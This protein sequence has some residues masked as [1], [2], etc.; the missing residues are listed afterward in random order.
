MSYNFEDHLLSDDPL[1]ELD[2]ELFGRS[3][4]VERVIDVLGQ[5]RKQSTSSTIGLVG[6]W[7]SGKSSVLT[8]VLSRIRLNDAETSKALNREKWLVAEFNPWLF[9]DPHALHAGFFTTLRDA[10]PS[11]QKWKDVR[12]KVIQLGRYVA[13]AAG[14]VTAFFGGDGEPAASNLID[15]FELNAVKQHDAISKKLKDLQQPVLIVVDDL[16]RLTATELLEV[17]KLVRLVGRL[18]Y[19]YYVLS[20]DEHTLV[21]LL[22]KTDLVSAND[23]RRAL[24]Y[25]EKIVQVRLDM[26]LLRPF[27][28]DRVVDRALLFLARKH[29]VDLD[30]ETTQVLS[31]RFDDVMSNRLRT[32]R[33][34][35]RLFGQLDAFLSAVGNEVHFGDYVVVTWLRTMEPGVYDLIQRRRSQLL[36]IE[37]DPMRSLDAPKNDAG[38]RRSSWIRDLKAAHVASGDVEDVLW[39]LGTLFPVVGDAYRFGSPSMNGEA[40]PAEPGRI[41]HVDYFDRFFA[42]GV[43]SDDIPDTLARDALA[44]IVAGRADDSPRVAQ[45]L[46]A[47]STDPRLAL[48]KIAQSYLQTKTPSPAL[49]CWVAERW[50]HAS[51]RFVRGRLENLCATLSIHLSGDDTAIAAATLMST[52]EGL[53]FVSHLRGAL[54]KAAHTRGP[55]REAFEMAAGSWGDTLDPFLATRFAELSKRYDSPTKLSAPLTAVFHRWRNNNTPAAASFLETA[56]PE[57]WGWVDALMW[58]A[59]VTTPDEGKTYFLNPERNQ[60][61]YSDIFDLD[62]AVIDCGDEIMELD[63]VDDFREKEATPE[64]RRAYVLTVLRQRAEYN[65]MMEDAENFVNNI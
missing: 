21:D 64:A 51:D 62:T 13:P 17:F 50:H 52:D 57:R 8:S 48:R 27:E 20:Y 12:G 63:H 36:S 16:D 5:V 54:V 53:L 31:R 28:V 39:L 22:A 24:E 9:S 2:D 49:I 45:L 33:S 10:F 38:A 14:L 43:P 19:V 23:D 40:P 4:L 46:A 18:P 32:P 1:A 11:T 35:K 56:V 41:S 65:A 3:H 6:A 15:Q 44:D 29:G 25:L 58:L 61:D 59:P 60:D 7:G 47:Y 42:F 30:D 55:D 26:P 37:T 34:L